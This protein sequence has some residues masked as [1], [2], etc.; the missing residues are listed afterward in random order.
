MTKQLKQIIIEINFNFARNWKADDII[1]DN[2]DKQNF[3]I[4][5]NIILR[6]RNIWKKIV[7]NKLLRKAILSFSILFIRH[8]TIFVNHIYVADIINVK[9]F[10]CHFH[11]DN[12]FWIQWVEKELQ[13][14]IQSRLK[15]LHSK[16]QIQIVS[17][18]EHLIVWRK[19]FNCFNMFHYVL[20]ICTRNSSEASVCHDI[21]F[22]LK[23]LQNNDIAFF[24]LFNECTHS[25][26]NENNSKKIFFEF[27]HLHEISF[28][29][30]I[31]KTFR[32]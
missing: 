23:C 4:D 8:L 27:R 2:F 29:S 24:K 13:D 10:K 30:F 17:D 7:I 32:Y 15:Y 3:W 26:L 25:L 9:S 28:E 20:N 14:D 12:C 22:N 31:A 11:S 21:S 6:S 19:K 5:K 18:D 1:T 16:L